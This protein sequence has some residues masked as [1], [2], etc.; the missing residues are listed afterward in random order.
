MTKW[1]VVA[2]AT[3][4]L[5][6]GMAAGAI[7]TFVRFVKPAINVV[8]YQD[9]WFLGD[10]AYVR[11]RYGSYAVAKAALLEHADML[12]KA[13]ANAHET[14]RAQ[15]RASDAGLFYARLAVAAERARNLQDAA[16]YFALARVQFERSKGHPKTEADLRQLV[17][18]L[19]EA[20]D[21]ELNADRA[22]PGGR[23]R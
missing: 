16:Q 21:R 11:Y 18:A 7:G 23:S 12:S 13:A 2:I 5:I 4:A 14:R 15:E 6:V 17:A 3:A 8:E 20:W 10:R 22:T 19:D 1:P 9:L